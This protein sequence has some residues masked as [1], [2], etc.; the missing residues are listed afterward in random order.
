MAELSKY[1]KDQENIAD[2]LGQGDAVRFANRLSQDLYPKESLMKRGDALRH[3]LWQAK[4]QQQYGTPLAALAGYAHELAGGIEGQSG[5]ER[6]M[7]L[8]NNKIG[9]QLGSENKDDSDLVG[10]ALQEIVNKRAKYYA[11]G[12]LV[13]RTPIMLGENLHFAKGGKVSTDDT[14]FDDYAQ[15]LSDYPEAQ[16]F[17]HKFN[18]QNFEPSDSIIASTLAHPIEAAKRLGNKFTENVNTLMGYPD[19]ESAEPLYQRPDNEKVKAALDLA[20]LAQTGALPFAP[21]DE[22]LMSGFK[23]PK[24]LITVNEPLRTAFPDIYAR[25]DEIALK[26][27]KNVA[28]EDPAL[29]QLFGVTRDDLYELRKT[30]TEGNEPPNIV[31]PNKPKGAKVA[32]LVMTRRNAQRIIDTLSEAEK[33]PELYKGMD[34]WYEMGPLFERF[35]QISDNPVEDFKRFQAITGMAS[36][37]SDVLTE[38][39]RGT[40]ALNMI[41]QQR[42]EDFLKHGGAKVEERYES[43]FPEDLHGVM[44]HPY[45]STAQAIPMSKY[46]LE[47]K[48][49]MDSPKVPLYIQSA[50]VP[51]TGF[52]IDLPVGDAHWSRGVGLA[53]VRGGKKYDASVSMPEL[54]S[55]GPWWREKIAK[56]LGTNAVNAQARAWGTFAPATGVTTPVG[57]PKLELIAQ[58]IMDTARAYDLSP[59]E[60]RDKL[61]LG[62]VYAPNLGLLEMF[63]KYK[64]GE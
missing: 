14:A 15:L 32:P 22:V 16:A 13:E 49:D 53:D 4:L 43:S 26:A 39:N 55:L 40:A 61:L 62:E 58:K 30:R 28:P 17:L 27:S 50:G 46:L 47:N 38:I 44:G 31:V 33:Y 29:K 63:K 35:K 20:G 48:V 11:E 9:R 7:D 34:A 59:E 6:E 12:G 24:R 18:E 41:K 56:P 3:I 23:I 42:F 64:S 21:E 1:Q 52:Q 5:D 36:P 45:H 54:L 8:I 10:K 25:P 19:L 2:Y 60:A 37:G 51:E 57:A